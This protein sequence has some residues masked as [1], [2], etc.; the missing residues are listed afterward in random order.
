MTHKRFLHLKNLAAYVCLLGIT[1]A[2]R[3]DGQVMFHVNVNT[4]N[5]TAG[6]NYYAEF[7]LTDGHRASL[8]TP[9]MNN[10]VLLNNFVELFTLH[11]N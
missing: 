2:A 11:Y 7:T 6:Q 5:L 8:G 3:V 9:D 1:L 10:S 4:S